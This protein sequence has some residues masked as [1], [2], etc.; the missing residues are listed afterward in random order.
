MTLTVAEV[1]GK[2][3]ALLVV[4]LCVG[5]WVR[6]PEGR[7]ALWLGTAA[8]LVLLPIAC[9]WGP[10]LGR[11]PGVAAPSQHSLGAVMWR[12]AGW[13]AAGW[14]AAGWLA[15]GWLAVGWLAGVGVGL[16]ALAR[17]SW[18]VARH[19]RHSSPCVDARLLDLLAQCAREQRLA[20]V[21]A[22]RCGDRRVSPFTA[23]WRRPWIHLPDTASRWG[24]DVL[25]SVLAH[26]CAHI[27]M[28]HWPARRLSA[29]ALLVH[30]PNPLAWILYRQCVRDQEWACDDRAMAS[31]IHGV[32]YAGDLVQAARQQHIAL[33]S[34]GFPSL[35]HRVL[36][37]VQG[38]ARGLAWRPQQCVRVVSAVVLVG[39]ALGSLG[40]AS[41]QTHA[42]SRDAS[43][44]GPLFGPHGLFGPDALLRR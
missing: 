18:L 11:W 33:A 42:P 31:G 37:A 2:G 28:R 40:V 13:L 22:L 44:A 23:G 32:R 39:L 8:A 4:T 5:R 36:R 7:G 25:Q 21:P 35:R 38:E 43:G 27:R 24:H 17:S 12:A 15:A 19:W 6:T 9:L 26:E 29:L 16:A 34:S 20:R 1:L 14:L 30:W 3:I 10:E 41:P